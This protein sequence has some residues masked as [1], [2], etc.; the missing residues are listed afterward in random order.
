MRVERGL[1][2]RLH[3]VRRHV[4]QAGRSDV[5]G[6]EEDEAFQR[7]GT[8]VPMLEA[9]ANVLGRIIQLFLAIDARSLGERR[10]DLVELSELA[11]PGAGRPVGRL[12][13]PGN[14]QELVMS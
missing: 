13:A 1:L 11:V 7:I 2:E 3:A 12:A 6:L 4:N 5:G 10:S 8:V 9:V 14:R